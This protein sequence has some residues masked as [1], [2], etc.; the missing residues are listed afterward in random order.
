MIHKII[1]SI[2][3]KLCTK[4]IKTK[5]SGLYGIQQECYCDICGKQLAF[6]YRCAEIR[7]GRKVPFVYRKKYA[8]YWKEF[9]DLMC[10]EMTLG[11]CK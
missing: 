6:S 10:E 9:S 4:H 7:H 2:F 8:R 11:A 5:M 1:H 3:P